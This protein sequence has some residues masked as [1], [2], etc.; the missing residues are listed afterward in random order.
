MDAYTAEVKEMLERRFRMTGEG[1]VY[2]AH[3]PIYG[4]RS[5]HSEERRIERYVITLAI[6]RALARLRFATLLD[7]GAAEGY[8]AALARELFGAAVHGC[9]LSQEACDRAREIFGVAG[10]AVDIHAL[11]YAD[12]QF[13]VVLCSETLEHVPDLARATRE[14]LRVA[15]AAV[16]VTVPRE[17]PRVVERNVR[18]RAL[19]AHI[20]AL[21]AHSFD[22]LVP[23][24][25]RVLVTPILSSALK[26]PFALAEAVPRQHVT[27]YPR[28]LL[29][30]YN[31]LVPALR[32]A[33]GRRAVRRLVRLDGMLA[34]VGPYSGM[35]VVLV[36]DPACLRDEPAAPVDA[37][38]VIDFT[39]PEHR[40]GAPPGPPRPAA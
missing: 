8:K 4:F 22:A 6:M 12:G 29:G 17:A 9:D 20:H 34:A 40:L 18:E 19:G 33:F 3:Q 13:D 10:E 30:L 24:A 39:V 31:A 35:L 7:V 38:R 5:P 14:L 36:K 11:P 23:A 2:F 25:T 16:V 27:R 21:D 26:I 32:R 1:G 15:R 28:A 37:D